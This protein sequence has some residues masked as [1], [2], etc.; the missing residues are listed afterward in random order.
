LE[1]N[2]MSRIR[3]LLVTIGSIVFG[4]VRRLTRGGPSPAPEV[5]PAKEPEKP[6]EPVPVAE[7]PP[8]EEEAQKPPEVEPAAEAPPPEEVPPV[9]AAE[10]PPGAKPPVKRPRRPKTGQN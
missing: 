8:S 9:K 2:T 1:E 7:I 6:P 5:L 4:P 3:N 10:E